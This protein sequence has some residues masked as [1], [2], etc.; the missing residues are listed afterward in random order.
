PGRRERWLREV[1]TVAAYR[2]RWHLTSQRPLDVE[3]D[4]H[5]IEQQTQ[6]QRAQ[7]AMKRGVAISQT[8]TKQ[9]AG[10]IPEVELP[11]GRGVER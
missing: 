4:V 2:D 6:R 11:R 8:E 9:P 7:A 5:S 3:T 10:L 1:A